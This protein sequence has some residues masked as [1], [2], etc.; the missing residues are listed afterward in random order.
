MEFSCLLGF[1]MDSGEVRLI[2]LDSTVNSDKR[3]FLTPFPKIKDAFFY[4]YELIPKTPLNAI[5]SSLSRQGALLKIEFQGMNSYGYADCHPWEELGD[6]SLPK[7]LDYFLNNQPT[8][9]FSQSLFFAHQD[10][11]S[12][13]YEKE[14]NL[15][16]PPSH[17]NMPDLTQ[18]SVEDALTQ[19][20]Q[21]IK[22]KVRPDL[23]SFLKKLNA[24]SGVLKNTSLRFD[25]NNAY[26]AHAVLEFTQRLRSL[27]LTI[28]LFE[29]PFSSNQ[30]E[31]YE[32]LPYKIYLDF[33]P[34]EQA[35]K[36]APYVD[37][38]V[39]KPAIQSVS[40]IRKLNQL[41]SQNIV[42]TYM[43]HPIGQLGA[44]LIAN[45]FGQNTHHGM[46]THLNYQTNEF[47]ECLSIENTKLIFN[48]KSLYKKLEDL[49]WLKLSLI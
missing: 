3:V 33:F 35:E 5:S 30:F 47:S 45:K 11:Y 6:L 37:G 38:F 24:L 43:D 29:D 23:N 10:A 49:K 40:L 15:I 2:K 26:S 46:L 42:T 22:I 8:N 20:F 32:K 48:K 19:G 39:L 4:P 27:P 44:A 1:G 13:P 12:T 9:L 7:Q 14:S 31:L 34:Y 36:L 17:F 18:N 16:S 21:F 28:D 25:F 41:K